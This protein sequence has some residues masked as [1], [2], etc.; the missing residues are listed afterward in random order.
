MNVERF[1]RID[2]DRYRFDY[3]CNLCCC[4]C[5]CSAADY[6][7]EKLADFFGIT[8]PKYQYAL[9]E[10]HRQ[11]A[12]VINDNTTDSYRKYCGLLYLVLKCVLAIGR[13]RITSSSSLFGMHHVS[14]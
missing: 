13:N 1:A 8:S 11:L 2:P 10:Y 5:G 4:C 12:Q 14:A 7:G 9:D 3:E 6:C